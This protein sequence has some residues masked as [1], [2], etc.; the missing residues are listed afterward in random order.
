MAVDWTRSNLIHENKILTTFLAQASR[1]K[2]IVKVKAK[3][4]YSIK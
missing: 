4:I 1:R 3:E 2:K